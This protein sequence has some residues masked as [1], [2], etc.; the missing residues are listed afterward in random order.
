MENTYALLKSRT[1]WTLVAMS[2]LPIV[3]AI[4][5]TLPPLWQNVVEI[6]LAAAAAYFHKDGVVKFGAKISRGQA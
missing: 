4:V 1:F 2:A 6:V 5:P 3:N